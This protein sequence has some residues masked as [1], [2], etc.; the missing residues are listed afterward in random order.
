METP[1][2]PRPCPH[3]AVQDGDLPRRVPREEEGSAGNARHPTLHPPRDLAQQHAR[4]RLPD[5]D[6]PV[7]A[8][9]DQRPPRAV[10]VHRRD[11]P[12]VPQRYIG[13]AAA[14]RP[15]RVFSAHKGGVR[16]PHV[17]ASPHARDRGRVPAELPHVGA[18]RVPGVDPRAAAVGGEDVQVPPLAHRHERRAGAG[19]VPRKF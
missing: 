10:R 16:R 5:E 17:D 1:E 8:A 3:P 2:P 12:P 9:A 7:D 19:V 14:S 11:G 6:L 13:P 4:G 18:R 15:R